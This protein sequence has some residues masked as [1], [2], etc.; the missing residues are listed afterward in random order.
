MKNVEKV[1][2]SKVLLTRRNEIKQEEAIN[3]EYVPE[4]KHEARSDISNNDTDNNGA[5]DEQ[6]GEL[7]ENDKK[8]KF[9]ELKSYGSLLPTT[10][11]ATR[12]NLQNEAD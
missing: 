5:E 12:E 1:K 8:L 10:V 9:K 7:N 11:K 3:Q 4:E 6:A 2:V